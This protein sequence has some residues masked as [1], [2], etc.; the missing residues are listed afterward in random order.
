MSSSGLI[1]PL[2]VERGLCFMSYDRSESLKI[3]E[4]Q[5]TVFIFIVL[6][7]WNKGGVWDNHKMGL[8]L[9]ITISGA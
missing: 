6:S 2:G 1:T 3:F 5:H 8:I 4:T 7:W 9:G